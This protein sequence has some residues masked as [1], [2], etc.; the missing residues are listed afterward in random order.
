[1]ATGWVAVVLHNIVYRWECVQC[2][3]AEPSF[4]NQLHFEFMHLLFLCPH[5]DGINELVA[6]FMLVHPQNL[7]NHNS[8]E[9]AWKS[10][11]YL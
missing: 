1:M 7:L 10:P 4:K 11:K 9:P 3:P 2:E 8:Q 5:N 6:F